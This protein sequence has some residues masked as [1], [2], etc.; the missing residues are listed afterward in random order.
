MRAAYVEDVEF[1]DI[2]QRDDGVCRLCWKPVRL[3]YR[4]PHPLTGVLDHIEPL[5]IGGKHERRNVQLAHHRC[6]NLKKAGPCGS[7]LRLF[8]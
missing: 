2:Y 8:A 7:A 3:Q 1:L 4:Y 5:A 6:N